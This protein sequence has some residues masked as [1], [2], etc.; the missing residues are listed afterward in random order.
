ML[1]TRENGDGLGDR[2]VHADVSTLGSGAVWS[3]GL[4]GGSGVV[5]SADVN[6]PAVVG[7]RGRGV[8]W[9]G[10]LAGGSPAT[11]YLKTATFTKLKDVTPSFP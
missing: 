3:G 9:I 11:R 1:S 10:R 4:A 6:G 5:W 7:T 2:N 8:V